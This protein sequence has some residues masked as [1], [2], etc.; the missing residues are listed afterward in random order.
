MIIYFFIL[1]LL[2]GCAK[3]T[4]PMAGE[5]GITLLMNAP[6]ARQVTI[7]GSFNGWDK[8]HDRLSGPDKNGW[9]RAYPIRSLKRDRRMRGLLPFSR[10]QAK[11]KRKVCQRALC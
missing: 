3:Y 8:E 5:R 2:A 6:D 11:R 9:W 10:L 1:M 4:G 7:V